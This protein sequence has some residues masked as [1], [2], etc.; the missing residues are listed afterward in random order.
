M[1]RSEVVERRRRRREEKAE[2]GC[3]RV[4]HA[5]CK[6][7]AKLASEKNVEPKSEKNEKKFQ[8]A[9]FEAYVKRLKETKTVPESW[10]ET[11]KSFNFSTFPWLLWR[12]RRLI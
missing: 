11:R 2:C 12:E 7:V 4:F 3:G 5:L 9:M 6:P 1:L 10:E 8:F